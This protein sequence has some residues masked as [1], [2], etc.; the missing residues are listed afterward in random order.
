[1]HKLFPLIFEFT[2][3]ATSG[4]F[5]TL[6]DQFRKYPESLFVDRNEGFETLFKGGFAYKGV[7]ELLLY[8]LYGAFRHVVHYI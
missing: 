1:M 5:K 3:A 7:R 6:G 4:V 8:K 2:Q